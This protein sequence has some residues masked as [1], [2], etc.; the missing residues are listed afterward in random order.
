MATDLKNTSLDI[1]RYKQ[2]LIYDADAVT[3]L[4]KYSDELSAHRSKRSWIELLN[5]YFLLEPD[6]DYDI[7]VEAILEEEHF[8]LSCF[9]TSACGRYAFWRLVNQ[10]APEAEA[11][12]GLTVTKSSGIFEGDFEDMDECTVWVCGAMDEQV[13]RTSD[14]AKLISRIMKLFQ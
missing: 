8:V 1:S 14:N 2:G 10:Q 6:R 12:L 3:L 7:F 4:G 5:S 11:Q 13:R 9:F